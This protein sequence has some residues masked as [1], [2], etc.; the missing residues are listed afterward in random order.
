MQL[1][2]F[3]L[4]YPILWVISI[5][6]HTLFYGVSNV[7]YFIVFRIVGYR[8]KVVL[9]NLRLAF[10]NKSNDELKSICV[11]FY[12][13]MC[14]VFMEMVKTMNLSKAAVKKRFK[15][16]NLEDLKQIEK[17]KSVLIVCAHYANWEWLVS[18]N[19]LIDTKGYAVYQKIANKYF[20]KWIRNLR[21]RWNTTPI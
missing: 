5:L 20:D 21:A 17:N 18:I 3:I 15:I 19:N 13:H 12:K 14:D 16:V 11:H 10:P 7:M 1:L 6:P 8:K 2:V 9:D 4:V